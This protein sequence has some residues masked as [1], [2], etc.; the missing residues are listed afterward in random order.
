MKN[1]LIV[2]AI[3]GLAGAI[4]IYLVSL[5]VENSVSGDRNLG[6]TPPDGGRSVFHSM[7]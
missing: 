5:E 7:G 1:I 4:A 2:A 6:I 3:A